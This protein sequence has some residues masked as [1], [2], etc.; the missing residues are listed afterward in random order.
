MNTYDGQKRSDASRYKSID[1]D[2]I[3]ERWDKRAERWDSDI[4]DPYCHL[5]RNNSY[6]VFLDIANSY[7]ESMMP[8]TYGGLVDIGCGTGLVLERFLHH[9]PWSIGIDI[10]PKML[11]IAKTRLNDRADLWEL[12]VFKSPLF[13]AEC[14]VVL[15]RGVLLSHYGKQNGLALLEKVRRNTNKGGFAMFD[16][17]NIADITRPLNKVGYDKD[18]LINL[19]I[20]AGFT[21]VDVHGDI[22]YP[23]LYGVAKV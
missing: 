1:V 12:D 13:P 18:S 14:L 4:E 10:S 15:S 3:K 2:Y 20:T 5:N 19:F 23:L 9:F 21:E 7:I 11:S 17:I 6:G 16:A 8:I 22:N